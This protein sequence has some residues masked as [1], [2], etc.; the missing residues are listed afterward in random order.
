M[1][2][3]AAVLASLLASNATGK[4]LV[5]EQQGTLV[6]S[7]SSGLVLSLPS[8]VV[9]VHWKGALADK[10]GNA[11]TQT[12]TVPQVARSGLTPPGAG[13]LSGSNFYATATASDAMDTTGDFSACVLINLTDATTTQQIL[14]DGL[15]S[16]NGWSIYVSAGVVNFVTYAAGASTLKFASISTGLNLICSGRAGTSQHI[17]VNL[18]AIQTAAGAKQA[19]DT[20]SAARIGV[21]TTG[22]ASFLGS[23]HEFVF[24]YATASD[25]LFTQTATEAKA[26]LGTAW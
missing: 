25:A 6:T 15:A 20:T 10:I 18:G 22:S 14:V 24:S 2:L 8:E 5:R 16:G 12:G 17:K 4:P 1:T 7:P 13:P 9:H 3:A 23:V 26:K 21:Y 11:W 19:A